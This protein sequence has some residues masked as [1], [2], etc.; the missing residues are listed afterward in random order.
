MLAT[1]PVE[2]SPRDLRSIAALVHAHAG[3]VLPDAKSTLVFSRLSGPFRRSGLPRF[4]DYVARLETDEAARREAIEALTTN[5]TG[6]FREAHHFDHVAA[7]LRPALM[8]KLR[9]G[10]RVRLWSAGS[11]SG[12][13]VHSLA[14]TVL[15]G[16]PAEGRLIAGSDIALLATDINT[17][18]LAVGEAGTYAAAGIDAI[19][20]PLRIWTEAQGDELRFRA[21]VRRLIRFRQLNLL[22]AWPIRTGFDAIF[23]RNTMI[24]FDEP[25]KARLIARLCDQLLPG[26]YLYIGHSERVTGPATAM[27]EPI[28]QTIYRKRPA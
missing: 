13:E 10:G 19:P 22:A 11:S 3:I 1:G 14:V 2:G 18:V 17:K 23:C 21:E 26:G 16:D 20:A 8:A 5:H 12:E 24:Y 9:A 25:T 28:G 15:G 6:L 4:A 27:L 7:D